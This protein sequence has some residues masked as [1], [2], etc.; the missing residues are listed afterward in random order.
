MGKTH[1]YE[2]DDLELEPKSVRKTRRARDRVR[3]EMEDLLLE[4]APAG[5]RIPIHGL[6]E[7]W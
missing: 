3:D 4:L 7:G 1:R 5:T 2:D 6:R